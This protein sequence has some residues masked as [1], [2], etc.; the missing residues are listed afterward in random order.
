MFRNH[1][2]LFEERPARRNKI[3]I[4]QFRHNGILLFVQKL[5]KDAEYNRFHYGLCV[6][7]Q[8]IL[9]KATFSCN[10]LRG[11]LKLSSFEL[12]RGYSPSLAG[13]PQM[14]TSKETL[15][16]YYEQQ[17]KRVFARMLRSN[18]STSI[19]GRSPSTTN[20]CLLFNQGGN[21]RKV[22]EGLCR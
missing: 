22:E 21:E 13:I 18:C 16:A 11:N 5:L 4:V 14:Q 17:S 12:T 20:A 7:K 2:I 1:G 6:P 9:S 8:E 15:P 19:Q 10:A 3:G